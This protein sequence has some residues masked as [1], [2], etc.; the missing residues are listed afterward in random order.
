MDLL[1]EN[2]PVGFRCGATVAVSAL[3]RWNSWFYEFTGTRTCAMCISV[4]V[5]YTGNS[6]LNAVTL[7]LGLAIQVLGL[8]LDV[9]CLVWLC[10]NWHKPWQKFPAAMVLWR[11]LAVAICTGTWQWHYLLTISAVFL[12]CISFYATCCCLLGLMWV[13]GLG[14][15]VLGLGLG[16]QVLVNVTVWMIS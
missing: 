16:S 3:Y 14:H 8:G 11:L 10:I 7:V 4:L 9:K 6:H 15:Q 12:I 13:C 1:D 2:H 5:D